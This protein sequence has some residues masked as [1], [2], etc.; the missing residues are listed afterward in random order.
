MVGP[1]T[2]QSKELLGAK[3]P[4]EID[5]NFVVVRF[6]ILFLR[7]SVATFLLSCENLNYM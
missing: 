3:Q 2:G 7:K 1:V 4:P 5:A 6:F